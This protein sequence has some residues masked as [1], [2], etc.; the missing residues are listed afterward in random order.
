MN[1]QGILSTK[2]TD[3]ATIHPQQ[4]IRQAIAKLVSYNVGALVV[5]NTIN[6]PIGILSERD[7]I[8]AA[9]QDE[10]IFSQPVSTLVSR[11]IIT[12]VPND[13]LEVVAQTM[14]EK[15]IRHIPVVDRGQ[16]VG[17]VSIGDVVKAQRDQYQGELYT[18]ETQ[19]LADD[20]Q[21]C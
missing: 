19:L 8:R 18:L 5:V 17:I 1:I 6:Q 2:G 9:A 13:D 21:A 3:V 14:T 10:A 12:G 11:E 16:L 20:S 15:R 7:I 4:S